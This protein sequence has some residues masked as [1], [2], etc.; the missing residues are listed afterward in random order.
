MYRSV[1]AADRA[2]SFARPE[3]SVSQATLQAADEGKLVVLDSYP[4]ANEGEAPIS[5]A[6]KA[7]T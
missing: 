4:Q 6:R 2:K 5:H 7:P 1:R 3:T